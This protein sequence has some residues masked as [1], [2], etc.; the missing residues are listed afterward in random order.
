VPAFVHPFG[1]CQ[2]KPQG[3]VLLPT[4]VANRNIKSECEHDADLKM[5]ENKPIYNKLITN[6]KEKSYI[7]VSMWI[8]YVI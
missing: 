6:I 4:A 1:D 2:N 7:A 3:F 8:L 5:E